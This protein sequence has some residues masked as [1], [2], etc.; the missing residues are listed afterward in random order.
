MKQLAFFLIFIPAVAFAQEVAPEVPA[1][2]PW[3]M[4]VLGL[5]VPA[6]GFLSTMF[7][8]N[9]VLMKIVDAFAFNWGKARNDSRVQ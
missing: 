9:N 3:L 6:C 1:D 7:R 5:I 4:V 8:S 2:P